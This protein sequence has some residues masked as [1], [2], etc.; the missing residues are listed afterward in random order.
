MFQT[1]KYLTFQDQLSSISRTHYNLKKVIDTNNPIDRYDLNINIKYI[2]N[3]YFYNQFEFRFN[4]KYFNNKKEIYINSK[5][6]R[7]LFQKKTNNIFFEKIFIKKSKQKLNKNAKSNISTKYNQEIFIKKFLN[8]ATYNYINNKINN[9]NSKNSIFGISKFVNNNSYK[10]KFFQ[11][12]SFFRLNQRKFYKESK[13]NISNYGFFSHNFYKKINFNF[14]SI[15][16][17]SLYRSFFYKNNWRKRYNY[18][19]KFTEFTRYD[20]SFNIYGD[21]L[22]N[23]YKKIYNIKNKQLQ[24]IIFYNIS[25]FNFFYSQ[26]KKFD[27]YKYANQSNIESTV[28]VNKKKRQS[29]IK[30]ILKEKSTNQNIVGL[31]QFFKNRYVFKKK[32]QRTNGRYKFSL[33]KGYFSKKKKKNF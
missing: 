32:N 31:H 24:Q 25:F 13:N 14:I 10:S 21:S 11:I 19:D 28:I 16:S 22:F 33:L 2:Q 18:F 9:L 30:Y 7:N 4:E 23:F 3:A 8:Y 26:S 12:Y 27:F 15:K 6:K 20:F 17:S 29:I 5:K 1:S